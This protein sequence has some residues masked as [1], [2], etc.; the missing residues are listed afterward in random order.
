[1]TALLAQ[2]LAHA[3]L[4][5]IVPDW[6]APSVVQALSTTRNGGVAMGARASLDLGGALPTQDGHP[7]AVRENRRRLAEFLPAA[8]VWLAQVHGTDVA[9]IDADNVAAMSLTPPTADAAVT[10]T[11][12]I[13]LGV[14]TADCLPVLFADRSGTVIGAAHAGWRG[15]A[16]G[17][18]EATLRAMRVPARDI[19]AW[20]GPAI[21]PQK[22]EV[23]SDV[24]DTHRAA[25]PAAVSCFAPLRD[26]KWLAD[27]YALAQ[28]RLQRAGVVAISGGGFCTLTETGRFFSYRGDKD[29]GRMAT[30]VWIG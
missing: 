17:V 4:D 3:G 9:G 25:D 13:V 12:G 19:V 14:R 23:G 11:P 21:G 5:W 28:L 29:A 16:A 15:L 20:L 22:F 27:L 18:L 10:R 2:R 7:G 30:L 8:P 24:F 26:G 6:A 1:M